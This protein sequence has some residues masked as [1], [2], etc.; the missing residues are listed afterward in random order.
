MN[1]CNLV[2]IEGEEEAIERRVEFRGSFKI[3][4]KVNV[5]NVDNSDADVFERK[6]KKDDVFD[7]NIRMKKDGYG[8][9]ANIKLPE[10]S[11][12]DKLDIYKSKEQKDIN[13]KESKAEL[14]IK[15]Y[16]LLLD[17]MIKIKIESS[18]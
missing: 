9:E 18:L 10:K 8:F 15:E 11:I 7:F 12:G 5:D 17:Y 13:G 2:K 14:Q 6:K 1:F 4:R 16:N 3:A